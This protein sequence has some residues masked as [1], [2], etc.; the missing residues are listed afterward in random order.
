MAD[1]IEANY[2][3]LKNIQNQFKQEADAILILR[4]QTKTKVDTLV[5]QGTSGGW[6]GLGSEAFAAEMNGKILP[7]MDKLSQALTEAATITG[8]IAALFQAAESESQ[9]FFSKIQL[10]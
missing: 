2:E 5:G 1:K 9:G 10:G 6:L 7:S 3:A 8:R 4:R